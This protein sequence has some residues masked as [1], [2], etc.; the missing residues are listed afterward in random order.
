MTRWPL[1]FLACALLISEPLLAQ[2]RY[3]YIEEPGGGNVISLGYPVP[4]PQD[5]ASPFSGF[6]T[7]DALHARHQ[8]LMLLHDFIEGSVVGETRLGREIWAYAVSSPSNTTPDGMAKS[9]A[10]INGGIHAR[11]WGTPELT[12]GLIEGFAAGAGDNWLYDYLLDHVRF[13]VLPVNNIDGFLQTQRYPTEVLIGR[14][15]RVDQWPRDGR[16]RRKNLSGADENLDTLGDHLSGVDLNR[17]SPPF[18]GP[19]GWTGV[20]TDLTYHGPFAQSEP[21]TRALAAAA[22]FADED[23]LRW[24]QDTHSF[25][26]LFFSVV[27]PNDRTNRIQQSLLWTF[28]RFHDGLSQERHGAGRWYQNSPNQAGTGIGVTAEYFAY[29]Y[30][31]P[32]WTLE[33]EPAN[34]GEDYGGFGANHDGFILPE[35]EVSRLRDDMTPTHAAVAYRMAGPPSVRSVEILTPDGWPVLTA[36]WVHQGNGVRTLKHRIL[37]PLVAGLDYQ[38]RLTFDKPMRWLDD[39]GRVRQ[40]PGHGI[41]VEPLIWFGSPNESVFAIDTDLGEWKTEGYSRYAT[42]R[43]EVSFTWPSAL[44][45]GDALAERLQ[46]VVNTTDFTGQLLDADPSSAVDWSEGAWT[47]YQNSLGQTGDFGGSDATIQVLSTTR[48]RARNWWRRRD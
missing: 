45:P 43:F 42:D 31:I 44:D 17:N 28:S 41:S 21:E 26:Q 1:Q 22:V 24:Y 19:G 8:D 11:E 6:R 2:T 18:F 39:D 35:S 9:S 32:S 48:E 20:E 33:I 12:T 37:E 4:I 29:T 15:P 36:E 27:T 10:L 46:L 38:L 30:Q 13:T 5:S 34:G 3:T 47:G 40:A 16:M 23:R 25:T 14:D 7:W